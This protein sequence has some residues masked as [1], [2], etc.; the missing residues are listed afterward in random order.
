MANYDFR[1]V[2][3]ITITDAM[4]TSSTVPE[5]VVATYAGGTTYGAGDRAGL[6]PVDGEAQLVYESLSAGNIGNPLPVPPATSTAFWRYVASVYPVYSGAVTYGL[7]KIV[8]NITTNVHELYESLAA[9]NLGNALTDATKWLNLGATNRHKMFDEIAA[10]Q[11]VKS[12]SIVA[13]IAPG[14]LVNSAVFSN[15][16]GTSIRMQQSVSGYDRT[17][18]LNSHPVINWYGFFYDPLI[19]RDDAAFMDIPPYATSSLTITITATGGTAGCGVCVLGQ[20]SYIGATQWGLSRGINDF[21]RIA[22]DQWGGLVLT[23]GNYSKQM[24]AEV[25]VPAGYESQAIHLLTG[26]RAT[27]VMFVASEDYD[28]AVVYGVLGRNWS[29]PI[30]NNGQPARLDIRGLV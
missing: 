26:I 17:I 21:S 15:L 27:P 18:E 8:S 22:E 19:T 23:P 3:P 2:R 25:Y 24:T 13:V 20:A 28:S 9:G 4:L 12:E 10:S 29:V 6:A 16:S 1:F 7:G 5:T 14:Q 11:T 30:N